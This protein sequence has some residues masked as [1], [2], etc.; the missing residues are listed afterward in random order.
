MS[1][2]GSS[3]KSLI[4]GIIAAVVVLGVLLA[5][6]LTQ[7]TGGQGSTE[8]T[9]QPTGEEIPKYELYWNLDRAEYEGKSEAGMS[10]RQQESD[11]YF[12]IRFFLEGE[13]VE[14]RAADRKV[15]NAIDV[16][17]VMGLTFDDNGIITGVVS[18]DD[19]PLEQ[20][21]WQFYVQSVGGKLL[22][23]N[24]SKA[25]NGL[26]VLLD[27]HDFTGI[28]DMT[29]KEAGV[30]ASITPISGD[31]VIALANL[32]GELTHVYVY[33]R[34]EFMETFEAECQHCGKVVEWKKWVKDNALP[35]T[36]GHYQLQN[37]VPN[38]SKQQYIEEDQKVCL[39]LNGKAVDG[40][41]N[42]RVYTLHYTGAQLAIMDTS[43]GQK[44]VLRGHSTASDQGGVVWV[45]YGQFHLYSGTLDGSDMIS[46][47]NGTAVDIPKG[48][49]FY[50]HGGTIIGGNAKAVKND[51]GKWT[52]GICGGVMVRG[53]FV[54][55]DGV[56][57]NGKATGVITGK[58]ANGVPTGYAR[59]YAGN[60]YIAT[61]GVFEMNGGTISGGTATYAGGNVYVDGTG[62]FNMKGGTITGGKVAGKGRN[63]GNV[64]VTSKAT[65]NLSGGKIINGISYNCAAN[66]YLNGRV[67]MTGGYIG[68]G[69]IYKWGTK[70][71]NKTDNRANVFNV[72]G[73][74]TMYGGQV[75]GGFTCVDTKAGDNTQTKLLVSGYATI[76]GEEGTTY[77]NLVLSQGG[78]NVQ[79][80]VGKLYDR[81]KIGVIA[82]TGIFTLPCAEHNVDNF[83]SDL[84]D[85]DIHYV[86]GCIALGRMGCLCGNNDKGNHFGKCDGTQLFWA[87]LTSTTMPTQTGNY[88]L[89]RV[90]NA[91][92]VLV[93]RETK[94]KEQSSMV[95]GA[96]INLDLNGGTITA[97]TN[98]RAF[99][100]HNKGVSFAITDSSEGKTGV[101]KSAGKG[102]TQGNVVWVRYGN[103]DLYGGTLDGSDYTLHQSWATG[104]GKEKDDKLF[105]T[106]DD[107]VSDRD[108][109]TV[110]MG[111]STT[112][113]MYGGT[114]IGNKAPITV[115]TKTNKITTEVNGEQVTTDETVDREVAAVDGATLLVGKN[116]TFNMYAGTI[117]DG[118]TEGY[119]GNLYALSGSV[120]NLYGGTISGGQA[121]PTY[122]DGTTTVKTKGWGGNIVVLS[123]STLNLL[124]EDVLITDGSSGGNGGNIYSSGT[125]NMQTGT[126]SN[127]ESVVDQGGN[128]FNGGTLNLTGGLVTGGKAVNGG[129]IIINSGKDNVL[130][131]VTISNGTATKA[132]GNINYSTT[133][134]KGS[135]TIAEGT[136]IT[137]GQAGT[138]GGNLNIHTN[139][140][141]GA[142]P[143]AMVLISGG[144]IENG[145]SEGNA[146]NADK[147]DTTGGGGNIAMTS[148]S[149]YPAVLTITGGTISGGKTKAN[150]GAILVKGSNAEVIMAGGTI[151]GNVA[152]WG[153]SV[154]LYGAKGMTLN[155]GIIEGGSTY[156]NG[157][158]SS[159]NGGNIYISGNVPFTMNGGTIKNG[160]TGDFGGNV[161]T[162]GTFTMNGGT[163]SGGEAK[164]SGVK[165][166]GNLYTNKANGK[167]YLNGGTVKNGQ[168]AK[169]GNIMLNDA[170]A[171]C[172][173]D[174]TEITGGKT[175]ASHGGNVNVAVGTF[176]LKSGTVSGGI[177]GDTAGNIYANGGTVI[178]EGGKVL[179]GKD[180]NGENHAASNIN[181]VGAA[182]ELRGGEMDGGVQ[183][184]NTTA[185]NTA[186]L[187]ISGAPVVKS[188][189]R[190]G[191]T[192]SYVE[193][194]NKVA[195][196]QIDK[197]MTDGAEVYIN[198]TKWEIGKFTTET[199]EAYTQYFHAN[200]STRTI[201]YMHGCVALGKTY[202]QCGSKDDTHKLGCSKEQLFWIPMSSSK[203][204]PTTTGNYYIHPSVTVNLSSQWTPEEN[205]VINL[206]LNGRSITC[207]SRVFAITKAGSNVTVTD[208]VGGGKIWKDG[209]L[210]FVL[211]ADNKRVTP[212]EGVAPTHMYTGQGGIVWVNNGATFNMIAGTIDGT[213]YVND[214][215][216]AGICIEGTNSTFNLYGGTVKGAKSS[217]NGGNFAVKGSS[218]LY[219]HGGT[220]QDGQSDAS[221]GNI[222]LTD[223]AY[224]EI[225]GDAIIT[226]G[227]STKNG[228]SIYI[229]SNANLVMNDGTITKG[230]TTADQGGNIFCGA[231]M[232][233][234]GGE[235]TNGNVLA[236]KNGG[237]I[238]INTKRDILLQG[239]KVSG[240]NSA[241]TG[242]N[243]GISTTQT[244]GSITIAEGTV[245]TGGT[246]TKNGGNLYIT[247]NTNS[248]K[249]PNAT[250]TV[251]ITGGT[252]EK[253]SAAGGGNIFVNHSGEGKSVLTITG[254]LI[255][256]GSAVAGGN[257]YVNAGAELV[258][259]GANAV[260]EKGDAT[261]DHGGNICLYGTATLRAGTVQNGVAK[262]NGGNI[263]AYESGALL[264]VNGGLITEG[265]ADAGG[266]IY[267]D[268]A[269]EAVIDGADAVI[270]KG[271]TTSGHGG[272]INTKGT[273]TLKAGTVR[274]GVSKNTG[275]NIYANGSA[276]KL[277]IEG[278]KVQ[279]GKDKNGAN[280][281]AA[282]INVVGAALELRGGEMDG[283]VQ[284]I[285]STASNGA[286]L[287]ISGAPVVKSDDRAGL[288]LSY[289]GNGT[290]IPVAQIDKAMTD[291]AE[292]Y[293]NCGKPEVGKFA[294]TAEQDYT[295]YFKTKDATRT[296]GYA[297]GHI[298]L[299]RYN[300]QC[301]SNA[302]PH[303]MGCSKERLF[304]LPVT[305]IPTGTGN[306]YINISGDTLTL[307]SQWKPAANAVVNLDMNGKNIT[308][309]ARV[310]AI[311]IANSTVTISDTVGTGK[312]YKDNKETSTA[313]ATGMYGGQGA[314][315]WV[316]KGSTVNLIDVDIDGT[317]YINT[318]SGAAVAV[319]GTGTVLNM[320]GGSVKG[321]KSQTDG[322]SIALNGTNNSATL[323]IYGTTISGGKADG[324]GGNIYVSATSQL[325]IYGGTVTG[326]TADDST[327]ANICNESAT[328]TTLKDCQINGGVS[329]TNPNVDI[330]VS[331]KVIITG[332]NTN[333]TLG[334]A[335][336]NLV[337]FS[338]E[339]NI[340]IN[341]AKGGAFTTAT[342][343]KFKDNF[344]SDDP[345]L[346]VD[347]VD[348]KMVLALGK[349]NCLCGKNAAPHDLGCDGERHFWLP[350]NQDSEL[351]TEE[352]YWYLTKTVTIT[353]GNKTINAANVYLD[354]NG[355]S[356][357][358]GEGNNLRF[359]KLNNA[360][361]KLTI[362][363]TATGGNMTN[364]GTYDQ[365]MLVWVAVKGAK[366]TIIDGIF[367]VSAAT[368][369]S[370]PASPNAIGLEAD[371]S[372]LYMYGGTIKGGKSNYG[373]GAVYG[374]NWN[375]I[376]HMYGGTIIGHAEEEHSAVRT[377]GTN[378]VL[379]GGSITGG[380]EVSRF[381]FEEAEGAEKLTQRAN[382]LTLSGDVIVDSIVISDLNP[383]RTSYG[384]RVI[385]P[386][387][388]VNGKLTNTTPI[389]VTV[390]DGDEVVI[391]AN[392]VDEANA[393]KFVA[394]NAGQTV[395]YLESGADAGKL[396]ICATRC[397][398]GSTNGTHTG[399]TDPD[400]NFVG[401]D[402]TPKPFTAWTATNVLPST[403]G[404]YYL[405]DSLS[406]S[407]TAQLVENAQVV[408]DLNGQTVKP[409]QEN[410]VDNTNRAVS[411]HNPGTSFTLADSK[412]TGKIIGS[413]VRSDQGNVVWVRNN[414][415][416]NANDRIGTF[417]MLGGTLQGANP[418][419]A[420]SGEVVNIDAYGKFYMLGGTIQGGT[421]TGNGGNIAIDGNAAMYMSGGTVTGGKALRLNGGS[422]SSCGGN[423]YVYNNATLYVTGGTIS[424]GIA[425]LVDA[426]GNIS[427][428]AKA[429]W[430]GNIYA[431]GAGSNVTLKNAT[432]SGGIAGGNGGSVNAAGTVVVENTTISGGESKLDR[433]GN[434]W[435]GGSADFTLTSGTIENGTSKGLGGN[436]HANAGAKIKL[437]GGTITGGSAYSSK[438]NTS[439]NISVLAG[440]T[441]L[442]LS[443]VK[444]DGYVKLE[445]LTS[446]TVSGKT[447][448]SGG[449][450]NLISPTN[451][452]VGTLTTGAKI[453]INR[454]AGVFTTNTVNEAYAEYF[455]SDKSGTGVAYASDGVDKGKLAIGK[456]YAACGKTSEHEAHDYCDGKLHTWLI[457]DSANVVVPEQSADYK[458]GY[459]YLNGPMTVSSTATY[460]SGETGRQV[461]F[462]LNGQTVT[463]QYT[464]NGVAARMIST[465]GLAGGS[466][467]YVMTNL[468]SGNAKIVVDDSK[469]NDDKGGDEGRI[470]WMNGGN[471]SFY[472]NNIDI[473][474][475]AA[476]T[477]LA[478]G[479]RE[480]KEGI[481][482]T[483]GNGRKLYLTNVNITGGTNAQGSVI[484][485][486]DGG[487]AVLNNVTIKNHK[488]SA[489]GGG[490]L[491]Q[492]NT[493]GKVANLTLSGKTKIS[494]CTKLD[495]TP[496]NIT[497]QYVPNFSVTESYVA[498]K[499][500]ID[501]PVN[502]VLLA[503]V[504]YDS[505]KAD[506]SSKKMIFTEEGMMLID[507]TV[508]HAHC[509][510][511]GTLKSDDE[512][513]CVDII[514]EALSANVTTAMTAD[515]N[516]YLTKDI[517]WNNQPTNGYALNVCFNGYNLT[518]NNARALRIVDGTKA[519]FASCAT[520]K[521]DDD[522]I[523]TNNSIVVTGSAGHDGGCFL[524]SAAGT[525]VNVCGVTLNG[526]NYNLTKSG[527]SNKHGGTV[528]INSGAVVNLHDATVL[529]ASTAA[530]CNGGAIRVAGTLNFFSG[531]IKGGRSKNIAGNIQI[532][533]TAAVMNMYGGEIYGGV[534]K[535]SAETTHANV[536]IHKGTLNMS[537]GYIDGRVCGWETSDGRLNISGDAKIY[538]QGDSRNEVK[539][540]GIHVTF[541][542]KIN[543][544]VGNV[545][546]KAMLYLNG[547]TADTVFTVE[548]DVT[549]TQER[550][551]SVIHATGFTATLAADGKTIT[552][553]AETP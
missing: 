463:V 514:Y 265:S 422:T 178:I 355:Q 211:D 367:D 176:T 404:Y 48:A 449:D 198:C 476:K 341:Y 468:S 123:G 56:I 383:E 249:S 494:D 285:N 213:G 549:L 301:G 153:G 353:S 132:G 57:K 532:T 221:A 421:S 361:S 495:G 470:I 311:D 261:T 199:E 369:T 28:W 244:A 161:W 38:L 288:T 107:V 530:S 271:T 167:F 416:W 188:D 287:K 262:Q 122:K 431:S 8:S 159:G 73:N 149:D 127:G 346:F 86:D 412:G 192:L 340:G 194:G 47:L 165:G 181:I 117:R 302:E 375:S 72:G 116:A 190:M 272:N 465:N 25:F 316:N 310:F 274:D 359:Y 291:G 474:L 69:K 293:I 243:I 61:G 358:N 314:I 264:T 263:Y 152:R 58:D 289:T 475:S 104:D 179:G 81:A 455:T 140:V 205:A 108:G 256:E 332:A 466:L 40:K 411:L 390:L 53:K 385:L 195:I 528:A 488:G 92:G 129:N 234:L 379:S 277:I 175:T 388:T 146:P 548:D 278:G 89:P 75:A 342:E 133:S 426:D 241:G 467:K 329:I 407:A 189:S 352:G 6:L 183:V 22:K 46:K 137:G 50:M 516:Y 330:T 544:K 319:Q 405:T 212:A 521:Y 368:A 400:G 504:E 218:K 451:I 279:G 112:F 348:G 472:M 148:V 157:S 535:D 150:G 87:P 224:V 101:V 121:G 242:G 399:Y 553:V 334:G 526:T 480:T 489:N 23:L 206:D 156:D 485:I 130:K 551:E 267:V 32:A 283:G 536:L 524:S 335:M 444:I 269:A 446:V 63:G 273:V 66:L 34:P 320:Y 351:P 109:G 233:L 85:A 113:N 247:P 254:G 5:V 453:G 402:G 328:S 458:V 427:T 91:E 305:T 219:V 3:R 93:P 552:F 79:M 321:A 240:G 282:S 389:K 303:K 78:D 378:N 259:D 174:G 141:N 457:W 513:I 76:M 479:A 54:M 105:G 237:N 537:G 308:C 501:A 325:N 185:S 98:Y 350:W 366:L 447:I 356:V 136:L 462:D 473:D 403:T 145:Y 37:D 26:E 220:I 114:I 27:I 246:A 248:G 415:E 268:E 24:S 428:A 374:N 36:T 276:A 450:T 500:G 182:L 484:R 88:Y 164:A 255:T 44:G 323:N 270:E 503:N 45:R 372:T 418:K 162:Q 239:V 90:M 429:G 538:A 70:E 295:K 33:E 419:N 315:L 245:I 391:T 138:T 29:G 523:A 225:N 384:R 398:C 452:T 396:Y 397:I 217:S 266:N 371:G 499:Q 235:V 110:C 14:L 540:D 525:V 550:V 126:I 433:G 151:T 77:D 410:G 298:A 481:A 423:I 173:V 414:S 380:V 508:T 376:F 201:G 297:D 71:L 170:D 507:P 304:W 184:V 41:A 16:N 286:S 459:W 364:N 257:I 253:G 214:S 545:S 498:C 275:G 436:L 203:T 434:V 62:E 134:G 144:T 424:N 30:G 464:G 347:F 505:F 250:A 97:K 131:G 20:V 39:D 312:I 313:T 18:L 102:T 228:G 59:G 408:L 487:T 202:C 68:G 318:H 360:A 74:F 208:T 197:P 191:L 119:G 215:N 365:G 172:V 373:G 49:Y 546:D 222:F 409:A 252:L 229:G 543:I 204:L 1:K 19:M 4:I 344:T 147:G 362:T 296:I 492:S 483:A 401:C 168:A 251:N 12:H 394:A 496:A 349:Y 381:R 527:T 43:E 42:A 9:A 187:K 509:A 420:G 111:G 357:V 154:A 324:K 490:I 461:Y 377:M 327:G 84:D 529:G 292:I 82:T 386:Y 171:I 478:N 15:I 299:G 307:T 417:V 258:V 387:I 522:G 469:Q 306:Y 326:G 106:A 317:G 231:Y 482:F 2:Q 207:K 511:A 115:L 128:I 55:N 51:K 166:G 363:D 210:Y 448:I 80:R 281:G 477:D 35:S 124:G 432:I 331:G 31:R 290:K 435:L 338:E 227:T 294:A 441:E 392:V 180:K 13:T 103:F 439:A 438:K 437:N 200:D 60:V 125:I 196:A 10:S 236:S 193:K 343:E 7:C 11:G 533:G 284:V 309:N 510:C 155:D 460:G 454:D 99:S 223:N 395:H 442:V 83:F 486:H 158:G 531:L 518:N 177:S 160:K 370:H 512:H 139:T 520:T 413:S 539:T 445:A 226:G 541:N 65:F 502:E 118:Y 493:A 382:H 94:A 519:N 333:L 120:L 17:D 95:E 354:L 300:C 52:N 142:K 547:V 443:N 425:S 64:F 406:Y 260:I 515:K 216:G 430:G 337:D 280:N 517:V 143:S 21:G 238:A 67:N 534:A 456:V 471:V 336:L 339:S 230:T 497:L 542:D 96:Q 169:G 506:N 393:S 100:L 186:S 491:V 209:T 322:G 440:A 232:Q 163:I 135:V 345:S